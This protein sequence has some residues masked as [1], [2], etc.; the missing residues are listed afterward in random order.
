MDAL[1]QQLEK[2]CH[3]ENTQQALEAYQQLERVLVQ[4]SNDQKAEF[5]LHYAFFMFRLENYDQCMNFFAQAQEYGFPKEEIRQ[6]VYEAFIEPNLEECK[7]NYETTIEQ[8]KDNIYIDEDVSFEDLDLW[9][10]P[11]LTTKKYFYN[12]LEEKIISIDVDD[13]RA[14]ELPR[15]TNP[16]GDY[17]FA[18][19]GNI[20]EIISYIRRIPNE[21]K[22]Y[23]YTEKIKYLFSFFQLPDMSRFLFFMQQTKIFGNQQD[24]VSYFIG[25]NAYLPRNFI[26]TSQ[27]FTKKD[28]EDLI[29]EIHNQRIHDLTRKRDNILL[30][31][32]IP[33]YNRGHRAYESVIHHLQSEYDDEIEIVVSNNG[34]TN[35]TSCLYEQIEKIQDARLCYCSLSE[36]QDL[37]FNLKNVFIHSNGK[38]VLCLSDEDILLLDRIDILLESIARIENVSMVKICGDGQQVILETKLT[39]CGKEAIE[40]C[41]F[42]GNYLSGLI[43]NLEILKHSGCLEYSSERI[44]KN[45]ILQWYPHLF[46]ELV[47]CIKGDVMEIAEILFHEGVPEYVE[48]E[49]QLFEYA[50]KEARIEQHRAFLFLFLDFPDFYTDDDI[51]RCLYRRL[52]Y[53]T[54]YLINMAISKYY[55]PLGCDIKSILREVF[56][57]CIAGLSQIYLN[58]DNLKFKE[59]SNMIYQCLNYYMNQ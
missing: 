12:R 42:T 34:C 53:K 2:I 30:T 6:I 19:D 54:F 20:Y 32:G 29:H 26:S 24:V 22:L 40:N 5:Y 48:Q 13:K 27:S 59:D 52:C 21:K 16:F 55:R 57:E 31:I 38:F 56:E 43:F 17:L 37:F 45:L 28:I 15:K 25:C 44:K 3:I 39:A 41:G 7:E 51:L 47:M 35:E 11:T 1:L 36:V 14:V 58:K 50:Y 9:F 8:L 46:L 10:I 18:N 23:V 33:S 4:A 49:S